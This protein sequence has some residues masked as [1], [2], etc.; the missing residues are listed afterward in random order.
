MYDENAQQPHTL[1]FPFHFHF[2]L[3]KQEFFLSVCKPCV[4]NVFVGCERTGNEDEIEK[5]LHPTRR[6]ARTAC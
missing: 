3:K 2:F 1:N 6:S 4:E 5:N